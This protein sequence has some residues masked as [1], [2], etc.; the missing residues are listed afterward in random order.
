MRIGLRSSLASPL[1]GSLAWDLRYAA[2]R[3]ARP[4]LRRVSGWAGHGALL[5]RK[6]VGRQTCMISRGKFL[7][8]F[9]F[10]EGRC[11]RVNYGIFPLPNFKV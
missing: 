6:K 7:R 9:T 3:P 5:A 10:R 2:P 8:D 11:Y 1:T 4:P